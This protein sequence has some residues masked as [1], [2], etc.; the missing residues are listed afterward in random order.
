MKRKKWES[1]VSKTIHLTFAPGYYKLF[2]ILE[3]KYIIWVFQVT[4]FTS[5]IMKAKGTL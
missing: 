5:D 3:F 1:I 4:F 2:I